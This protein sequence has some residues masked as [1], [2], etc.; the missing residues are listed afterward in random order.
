[1]SI[2]NYFLCLK[3][4]VSYQKD[5]LS[6]SQPIKNELYAVMQIM[7]ANIKVEKHWAKVYDRKINFCMGYHCAMHRTHMAVM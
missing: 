6:D 1:M 3:N 4:V 7:K 5:T 2:S